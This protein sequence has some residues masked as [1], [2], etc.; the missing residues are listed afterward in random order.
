M[1]ILDIKY[2]LEVTYSHLNLT[3]IDTQYNAKDYTF[4]VECLICKHQYR[5]YLYKLK[6]GTKCR[7]C[8]N[9]KNGLNKRKPLDLAKQEIA[10]YNFEFIDVKFENGH[11]IYEIKC[12]EGHIFH[13]TMHQIKCGEKC[14]KCVKYNMS[15]LICRKYMEY[16]FD[17]PFKKQRFDWLINDA[18]YKLELDGYN[19]DLKL[20]MEYDGELHTKFVPYFHRTEEQFKKR[21]NDD[22]AKNKLCKEHN[23]ILFRIPY[24]V[25][26]H[27]MLDYIKQL[28]ITNNI[29]FVDKPN[30]KAE[31]LD[32]YNKMIKENNKLI[33]EKLQNSIWIRKNNILSSRD[34]ICLE[35]INCKHIHK[36]RP[37]Y[38]DRVNRP[39]P[40]CKN[41]FIDKQTEK[42][43]NIIIYQNWLITGNYI[44]NSTPVSIKCVECGNTNTCIPYGAFTYDK[45]K[46]CTK[47]KNFK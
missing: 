24:T 22:L 15:E 4:L 30:I 47:C 5:Y 13:K 10:K 18:G 41:C 35:C 34:Q 12:T 8:A 33:D 1:N 38:L 21:Q 31:D 3:L 26:Y 19:D 17:T 2:H 45:I 27:D 14:P 36:I 32:V 42:L 46:P 37:D 11:S 16:L 25:K 29:D 43:Q 7:K 28:C 40:N 44:N 9:V 20:A 6:M 23:I 39:I